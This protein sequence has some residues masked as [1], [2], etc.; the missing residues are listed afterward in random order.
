MA[1]TI[2]A[3]TAQEGTA[4]TETKSSDSSTK[5][6]AAKS[7]SVTVIPRV[8]AK[9]VCRPRRRSRRNRT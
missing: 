7:C 4:T 1:A 3:W 6:A 8:V 2:R 9:G 5:P